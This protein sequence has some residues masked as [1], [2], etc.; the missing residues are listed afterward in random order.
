M[1]GFFV[2]PAPKNGT[3]KQQTRPAPAPTSRKHLFPP[4]RRAQGAFHPA[5]NAY[6]FPHTQTHRKRHTAPCIVSQQETIIRKTARLFQS[7]N[8]I[9][10]RKTR[11]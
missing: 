7:K 2:P 1:G 8:A 4:R 9:R 3:G 6:P 5:G 10:A 11:F